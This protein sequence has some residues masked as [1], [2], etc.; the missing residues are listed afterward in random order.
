[1]NHA[2]M[3]AVAVLQTSSSPHFEGESSIDELLELVTIRRLEDIRSCA[4]NL[5]NIAQVR[6]FRVALCSNISSQM[7]MIDA[8]DVPINTDVFGWTD[9]GQRWW[10]QSDYALYSPV[11]RACRYECEAFWCDANGFH[12]VRANPYLDEIEVADH[13]ASHNNRF[14]ME[15]IVPVHLPF[16]QISAN[17]FPLFSD[18]IDDFEGAF[19]RYGFLFGLLTRRLISGYV[20]VRPDINRIPANCGLSKRDVQCLRWLSAGKTDHEIGELL[21]LSR[22]TVRY[23]IDRICDKLSAVNRTQAVFKASQLGYIGPFARLI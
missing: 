2:Q 22:S 14:P 10:E 17:N 4:I 23:H 3:E 12:A 13:F 21:S 11:P 5:R 6:G 15:I 9:D 1:M 20:S 8:D 7:Q 16:G 19:A 18:K